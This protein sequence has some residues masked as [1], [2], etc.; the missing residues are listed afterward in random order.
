MLFI[1]ICAFTLS[2]WLG[3]YLLGRNPHKPLLL[4]S[5]LGLLAYALALGCAALTA[6]SPS[7]LL[8]QFY[9]LFIFLPALC[10]AGALVCLLPLPEPLRQRIDRFWLLGILP[11]S[12][13]TLL[14][15]VGSGI[16]VVQPIGEQ[17]PSIALQL[18]TIL[19]GS[20]LIIGFGLAVW[21]WQKARPPGAVGIIVAMTI[22]FG[23]GMAL[24]IIPLNGQVPAWA[25]LGV[26]ID[27]G[28]LGL[29]IA[30][31]DSF[32]EGESL[33]PDMARSLIAATLS[34]LSFGSLVGLAILGTS[35]TPAM[36]ALLFGVVALAVTVPTI[37]DSLQQLIDRVAFPKTPALQQARADL[38]ESASTLP[39]VVIGL[40]LTEIDDDEFAR[41]TRR[42]LSHLGDL[43]RLAANPLTQM[44][45]IE[46]R[47]QARGAADQPLERA[48]ELKELLAESIARL[49][50]RNTGDFGTTDAWRYYNALYFPYV[51]G[52]R[53]FNRRGQE[54]LNSTMQQARDWF[55]TQVPER[56]LHNWQNAAAR[57]VAEDL[58]RTLAAHGSR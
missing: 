7:L 56:T 3:L 44:P 2:W 16:A 55:A 11:L 41:L 53:P 13:I 24:L 58:R 47:L 57:I 30:L 33:R 4:R 26:G 19:C 27:L 5:G 25:I 22:F 37:A 8:S 18:L 17:A 39:K 40:P 32:D 54:E 29:T 15:A 34:A 43:G 6:E 31:L 23:L 21:G 52:L 49:K 28:A 14:L 51:V 36:I 20:P 46:A 45:V 1:Y 35:A 12:L 48:A 38:R 42:A 50:P 9:T 10:W